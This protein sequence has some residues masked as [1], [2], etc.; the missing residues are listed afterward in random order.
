MSWRERST[1]FSL[2]ALSS[3]LLAAISASAAQAQPQKA[4]LDIL[5]FDPDGNTRRVRRAKAIFNRYLAT[6]DERLVFEPYAKW[7]VFR[8]QLKRRQT[9]FVIVSS[10]FL[11]EVKKLRT[12]KPLLI[13]TRGG[14]RTYRK[15]VVTHDPQIRS[16]SDLKGRTFATVSTAG[17]RLLDGSGLPTRTLK[18][19]SVP[20]DMDALLALTFGHV[21]GAL[22]TQ[23]SIS[24]LRKMSPASAAKVRVLFKT[25]PIR[26]PVLCA[27]GSVSQ[28]MLRAVTSTLKG[29]GS[30]R[31]GRMALR[32][33]GYDRWVAV[34][35]TSGGG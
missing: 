9:K 11:S 12:V 35:A 31:L 20:K 4:G 27:V 33:L 25:P 10:M 3:A 5:F 1:L 14:R 29:M 15:L 30:T 23:R 28:S 34:S 6:K 26:H 2:A 19:I 22:V 13:L 7:S 21:E 18:T 17:L 8:K 24:I 32:F 16:V